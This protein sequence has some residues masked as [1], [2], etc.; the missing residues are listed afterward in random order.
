L[1]PAVDRARGPARGAFT[2]IELLVVIAII[3]ILAGMLLPA[4]S[5]SKER[6]RRASCLNNVRQ[7]I[8]ATH[9]YA[10]DNNDSLPVGGTDNT[11][12]EDTHTAIF[13]TESKS[14]MLQ[15]VGPIRVMDCPNLYASFERQLDWRVHPSYGVAVGYHYLGGH[16]NTPWDPPSG[17]TNTWIS[18]K[19]SAEDPTLA[20][21]AD[22]NIYAYSFLRILAP[23]TG[24]GPI[25]R[26]DGYFE[27][28]PEAYEQTPK[29]A[30]GQGGNVGRLDG[31]AAWIDIKRMKL[32]RTSQMW[33]D[34]GSFGYW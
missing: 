28:H 33:D 34:N 31:S 14:N 16:S 25:V 27:D 10:G 7:F 4:L 13:S 2:L 22:L 21:V 29:E 8:I 12:Q 18:P 15:Y 5:G 23:H 19:K 17:T 6:S 30:G 32:Y 24:R 3:A 9:I 26:E 1:K 20:L 11:N